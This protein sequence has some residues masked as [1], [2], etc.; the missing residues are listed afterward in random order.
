[1]T[2]RIDL[3]GSWTLYQDGTKDQI[4]CAIPGDIYNA[5]VAAQKLPDPYYGTNELKVQAPREENWVIERTIAVTKAQLGQAEAWL[6]F[7]QVDTIADVYVNGALVGK[8]NNQ[9]RRWQ[10]NVKAQ[11][12]EGD[13][14]LRIVFHSARKVAAEEAK[15]TPYVI[16]STG[17]NQVKSMNF[18]RKTQCHA[19][20]DWGI[21]LIVAGIYGRCDLS[22]VDDVRMDY[23]YTTQN[24]DKGTVSVSVTAEIH[25]VKAGAVP[26]SVA[27]GDHT[28]SQTVKVV[29]GSNKISATMAIPKPKLWWPA[30]QG[31]QHLYGLKVT[32]GSATHTGRLGLRTIELINEADDRGISMTFRVNGN[33]LFCKGANWIPADAMPGR[34]DKAALDDL[35]ESA[36]AANMNMLRIW[37]GGEFCPDYFYQR[38]DELGLLLWHDFMFACALY[39]SDKAFL[40]N[41][42]EEVLHNV[43]RLRDH[44][45]IALWCGDNECIGALNWYP[46]SKA[47]RERYVIN[48]SKLNSVLGDAAAEAD[49]TRMFWPSSPCAG[50]GDFADG[51]HDDTKGD[52]HYWKVWHGG[53]GMESYF[54]VKPRFCSEFGYQ[55]FSSPEIAKAFCPP[56]HRNITSPTFELHQKNPAGNTKINEMF[57]RYFRMPVGFDHTLWLSQLQQAL[58][59]KLGVEFWRHQMPTC[60]GTLYWQLNDNWP[61]ASWSSLEFG[62]KWKMLHHHARRFFQPVIATAFQTN[63]N[64]QVWAVN[65][66]PHAVSATVTAAVRDLKGAV[67][68]TKTYTVEV[69]A[70]ASVKIDEQP[71]AAWTTAVSETFLHLELSAEGKGKTWTHRNL[72]PFAAYK[73]M[74]LPT[75]NV[76]TAVVKAGN[77]FTVTLSSDAVAMYAF[78]NVEGIRGEFSDNSV[79]LLPGEQLT[80]T[81]HAKD[82]GIT[83]EAVRAALSV[84]HLQQS[85]QDPSAVTFAAAAR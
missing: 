24:H 31:D 69:P 23:V 32:I 63:D 11:L 67:V 6:T 12:K 54:D 47:N 51:W 84:W 40:S 65:D 35:L 74:D 85:Y 71:V 4:P 45:S 53:A 72:H 81:F 78:A 64:V 50:P 79:L 20:W 22:F 34:V 15:K 26:M 42:R 2:T 10:W 25:A 66:Q 83:L 48:W 7:E 58:A 70:N 46:E 49:P 13:N 8:A 56:E 3:A 61:V 36:V 17:N 1:M 62:G 5:L 21:C 76:T 82:Q 39:P 30:G 27:I 43:K 77:D 41:V 16:P 60:M 57:A 68:K 59:I 44:T 9:F 38:C 29:A 18:V 28:I 73:T 55:S 80:L 19:G 37:G 75:A 33:D 52:M 14:A